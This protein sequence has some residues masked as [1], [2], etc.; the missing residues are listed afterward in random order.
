MIGVVDIN[1]SKRPLAEKLAWL[2]HFINPIGIDGD[3]VEY[4]VEFTK[5]D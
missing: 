2:T 3:L 1:P 4:L 5:R